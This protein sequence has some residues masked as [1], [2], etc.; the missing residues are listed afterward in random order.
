MKTLVVALTVGL[1]FLALSGGRV[2]DFDDPGLWIGLG[3][4]LL[5]T[6][7]KLGGAVRDRVR[8]SGPGPKRPS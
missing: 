6:L 4:A 7:A 8:R 1:A 3:V 2:K 5:L